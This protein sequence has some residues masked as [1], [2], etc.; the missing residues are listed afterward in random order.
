[1][2]NPPVKKKKTFSYTVLGLAVLF[3]V[4][5]VVLFMMKTP[6]AGKSDRLAS[7]EKRLSALETKKI[8]RKVSPPGSSQTQASTAGAGA[9]SEKIAQVQNRLD[10]MEN[11]LAQIDEISSRLDEIEQMVRTGEA[12]KTANVSSS[13]NDKSREAKTAKSERS[14]P[15]K[16]KK[17]AV[18]AGKPVKKSSKKV[19][20]K[21]TSSSWK[22]A[23]R[24]KSTT[25]GRTYAAGS[26]ERTSREKPRVK[27]VTPGTK[28]FSSKSSAPEAR[29][30]YRDR[31]FATPDYSGTSYYS[32]GQVEAGSIHR[33]GMQ[34][35]PAYGQ[36]E[37]NL[38]TMNK[39]APGMALYPRLTDYRSGMSGYSP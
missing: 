17:T 1:M 24:K 34:Y 20:Q 7:I 9:D 31:E 11:K 2:A 19:S 25:S 14:T 10:N 38:R 29:V 12:T 32:G 35:T 4:I 26:S 21:S 36:S 37:K 30:E 8:T 5:L 16:K 13:T 33:I 27:R 6:G 22:S 3:V 15:P 39:M 28:Q 18:A 23:A